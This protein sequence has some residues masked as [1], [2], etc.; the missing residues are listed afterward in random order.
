MS[1]NMAEQNR[2]EKDL[3][4][5]RSRMDDRLTELQERLSPGQV[6]DDL[7]AYFRGSDGADFGRN[8]LASVKNNPLP[9]AL[10]GIGLTWLMASNPH[11][12][13]KPDVP[14]AHAPANPKPYP[15]WPAV[16]SNGAKGPS[17]SDIGVR[18]RDAE[19]SVVRGTGETEAAF[20]MR[21]DDARGKVA[22]VAREIQDTAESYSDR[23]GKA[24][25][26]ASQ[27]V[28]DSAHELRDGATEMADKVSGAAGQVADQVARK[29]QAAREAGINLIATIS[30]NPLV[31]GAIGLAVGA[32]LGALIPQSEQEEKA[33]G[34]MAAQVREAAGA[35]AL[36]VADGGSKVVQQ[37]LDVGL[38]SATA[39]GLTGDKS[40]SDIV[41][42]IRSGD[43]SGTAKHVAKD[44][45][46]AADDALR[47]EGLGKAQAAANGGSANPGPATHAAGG[48]GGT[49]L[50]SA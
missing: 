25:A 23:I 1:D 15:G 13:P 44:A 20:R 2:I 48:A 10:T 4:R 28:T 36:Q 19:R 17:N 31:L 46:Q 33:L 29:T 50:G 39:H 30:E 34:G 18:I 9:A 35:A 5:T 47:A 11:P 21:V 8:L 6:V 12:H 26:A 3:E 14:S 42:G 24:L 16:Y 38:K 27:M 32:L 37:V 49:S 22:G 45:M 41:S 40:I 43:L 7:M